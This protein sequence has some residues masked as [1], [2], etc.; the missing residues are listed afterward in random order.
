M[1]L[2]AAF[3]TIDRVKLIH[4]LKSWFGISG[5]ALDWFSSYLSDRVQ[6]VKVNNHLSSEKALVCGVPQGSVLGPIL[7]SLYTVPLSKVIS[8][9]S[10]IKHLLYAD[11]TQAYMSLTPAHAIE[12]LSDLGQCLTDIHSWMNTNM[13]KL[14]PDK[15]EFCVFGTKK[16]RDKLVHLFP[17]DILGSPLSPVDC[18]KNLGFLFDNNLTLSSQISTVTKA[19]FYHIRDL[20]RIRKFLPT[21]AVVTLSNALVSSKLDYCN[22]LYQGIAT[23]QLRRLQSIQNTLCRVIYKKSRYTSVTPLLK[24]LHWLPVCSRINFKIGLLTYKALKTGLPVYLKCHLKPYCSARNTRMSDP[25]NA[26]LDAPY[27]NSKI[28]KSVTQLKCSFSYFAPRFWNSLPLD[29]RSCGSI[30]SFRR[31]LKGHLFNLAFS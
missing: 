16:Q 1:D 24:D 30:L 9:Y 27:Y 2:S 20:R 7:F 17:V 6:S 13:L 19:C 4:R 29:I 11:D 18:V 25:A 14:N 28:H 31:R 3:D 5:I 10:D 15:T 22:S 21:S 8:S 26:V 23:K 12:S